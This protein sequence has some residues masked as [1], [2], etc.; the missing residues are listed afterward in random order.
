M[1][2]KQYRYPRTE[3]VTMIVDQVLNSPSTTYADPANG[4]PG[5]PNTGMGTAPKRIYM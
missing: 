1:I 4:T 3:V 2:K 5:T